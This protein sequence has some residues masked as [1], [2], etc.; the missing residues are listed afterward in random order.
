MPSTQVL[1]FLY[2]IRQ[3]QSD[4]I[5]C[6]M[7]QCALGLTVAEARVALLLRG[8]ADLAQVAQQLDVAVS[9]VRT[10]LKHAFQKTGT[11]RQSELALLVDRLVRMAPRQKR[12][13]VSAITP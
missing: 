6:H 9:T 5:G 2:D 3:S 11:R 1:G 8:H 12:E 7:L 13:V 10:H 4:Q